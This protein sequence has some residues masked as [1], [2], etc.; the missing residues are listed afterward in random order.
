MSRFKQHLLPSQ[1]DHFKEKYSIYCAA[2]VLIA[3]AQRKI[4]GHK[5]PRI[6]LPDI[7]AACA[8]KP[9]EITKVGSALASAETL[10]SNF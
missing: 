1:Q 9:V 6:N 10:F 3:V 8:C 5:F 2:L 4:E 7:A